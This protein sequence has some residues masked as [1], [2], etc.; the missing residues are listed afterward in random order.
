MEPVDLALIS[1]RLVT[2]G[3]ERPGA[4][5]VSG[6]RITDVLDT[7]DPGRLPTSARVE[8]VGE[9]A[10]LAGFVDS[11]VHVNEPGR[12]EWEGFATA[13]RAAAAAGITTIVDMPLNSLPPTIDPRALSAKRAVAGPQV[14][15]DVGFWGGIVPGSEPHLPDLVA[16]GVFGCKVFT[17]ASGVPEYGDFAPTELGPLA[18]RVAAVGATLLVHAEDPDTIAAATAQILAAGVDPRAHATWLDGRPAEAERRAIAALL[19]AARAT[20]ARVHVLHLSAADALDL[21]A[22]AR[23]EGVAVTVETCPHYLTLAAE[24]IAD[25]ATSA[26]C[27]PPIRDRANRD[28]LWTALADGT[29]DAIVSDHSPAPADTKATDTGSFV[30]AWGGISSLQLGP[31]LV[32][33]EARRRGHDLV[34]LTRWMAAGPARVAGLTR[35]GRLE[36]GAD[37]DLVVFDPDLTFTVDVAALH[38]RHPV[39]PYD[40]RELTGRAVA[41]YLRGRLVAS[42]GA[43]HDAADVVRP[44]S[45]QLLTRGDA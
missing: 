23:E 28:R 25:G 33:T 2:D 30:D 9:L 27:A 31:S 34:D 8:D 17:C 6:G 5:V 36:V 35:K 32:W 38:H 44:P 3:G 13:T 37:A 39:S 29:I 24:E 43:G 45:G 4:V 14:S 21:L 18:A 11:H 22:E 40:G 19:T 41:T 1:R 12:T 16:A 42:H 10:V 15:V 26:K 7:V 20:G